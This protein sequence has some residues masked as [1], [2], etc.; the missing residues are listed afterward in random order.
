MS[1]AAH[2]LGTHLFAGPSREAIV[3]LDVRA[4]RLVVADRGLA[5]L[6]G[7]APHGGEAPGRRRPRRR[8]LRGRGLL[9]SGR[10]A[11]PGPAAARGGAW[12]RPRDARRALVGRGSRRG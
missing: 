5:N 4:S 7:S 9:A 3:L 2:Q 8:P 1:L 11:L 10:R 12:S 6:G